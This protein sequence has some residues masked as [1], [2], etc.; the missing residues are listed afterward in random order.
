MDLTI[1]PGEITPDMSSDRT[2]RKPA[3]EKLSDFQLARSRKRLLDLS[4]MAPSLGEL[5]AL[6]NLS[7]SHFCRAFK[8][9]TGLPPRRFQIAARIE[10]ARHLLLYTEMPVGEIGSAVGYDDAAYFS[11]LFANE[12]GLSP[13]KWRQTSPLP[14]ARSGIATVP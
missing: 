13:L 6:C 10:R 11:R 9:A 5:A 2:M 14:H 7:P 8:R 4:Q 12:T 3:I 1:S